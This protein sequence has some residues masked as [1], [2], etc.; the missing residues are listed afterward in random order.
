ML[1]KLLGYLHSGSDRNWSSNQF[2][3]SF[4]TLKKYLIPC[5]KKA[6]RRTKRDRIKFVNI[7]PFVFV[8]FCASSWQILVVVAVA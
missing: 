8:T 3:R 2:R 7:N 1:L 5:D 6:Q 4:S